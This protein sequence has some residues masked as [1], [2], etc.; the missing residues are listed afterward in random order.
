MLRR[1]EMDISSRIDSLSQNKRALLALRINEQRAISPAQ[2]SVPGDKRLVA[3]VVSNPEQ[4]PT[5]G[6]LRRFLKEKLPEYMVPSAFVMLDMLPLTPNGKVDR[7]ALQAPDQARPELEGS[8][9]APR[10]PVE[11]LLAGKG[12]QVLGV[13]GTLPAGHAAHF[14]GTRN[15]PGGAAYA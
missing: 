14:S 12:G 15:L 7:R 6:E 3:Y 9:V 11:E 2:E 8:F 1:V 10:S 4:A 13:G 5:I